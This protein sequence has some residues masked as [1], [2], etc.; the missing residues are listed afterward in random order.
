MG[1]RSCSVKEM[2]GYIGKGITMGAPG[3]VPPSPL[4]FLTV[5][6]IFMLNYN[7]HT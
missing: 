7:T 3:V 2:L 4:D 1:L 6:L 5:A